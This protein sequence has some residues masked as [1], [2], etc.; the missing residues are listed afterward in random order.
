MLIDI[1]GY[2]DGE[3]II[4]E[5]VSIEN[6]YREEMDLNAMDIYFALY[7]PA[8]EE[9]VE[10]A[11]AFLTI[12]TDPATGEF[13]MVD[14]SIGEGGDDG[15]GIYMALNLG[16]TAEDSK[17]FTISTL[18]DNTEFFYIWG[19]DETGFNAIVQITDVMEDLH[20][21]AFYNMPDNGMGAFELTAKTGADEV[22]ASADNTITDTDG[23]WLP[24]IGET[25][26][27]MTAG[28]AEMEKL[29]ME[30]MGM[31]GKLISACSAASEDFA[32]L[33]SDLM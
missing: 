22:Y 7:D 28:D 13:V 12:Y 3:A 19:E 6:A 15:E 4:N 32:A 9:T 30:G 16:Q 31:L 21:E 11:Y 10:E 26:D 14:L 17:Y 8:S 20:L 23:A 2:E 33:I 18:D 25:V 24:T 1:Y 27:I 5:F 29:T